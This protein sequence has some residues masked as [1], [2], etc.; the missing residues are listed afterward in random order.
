MSKIPASKVD[1]CLN[2]IKE[3][4]LVISTITGGVI[5]YPFIKYID[6]TEIPS[7]SLVVM[8]LGL[9]FICFVGT[10]IYSLANEKTGAEHDDY[11][12]KLKP[13]VMYRIL[14]PFLIALSIILSS[15][16]LF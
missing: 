11:L 5:L 7:I 16:V 15:F 1:A 2:S 6:T 12:E 9:F 8:C 14:I 10:Q 4:A 3:L 13:K